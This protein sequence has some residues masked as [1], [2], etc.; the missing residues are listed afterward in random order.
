MRLR[1]VSIET[2]D[3]A[4]ASERCTQ[5]LGVEPVAAAGGARRFTLERGVVELVEGEAGRAT[6]LFARE[7]PNDVWAADPGAHGIVVRVED[8]PE[9]PPAARAPG[10]VEAIDHVVF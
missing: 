10:A 6:V 2:R 7:N 5:L 9:A 4:A 1:G 8:S 3:V